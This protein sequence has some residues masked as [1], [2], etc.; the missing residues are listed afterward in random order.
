MDKRYILAE[1]G[2]RV[3]PEAAIVYKCSETLMFAPRGALI[4]VAQS[5]AKFAF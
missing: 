2:T 3:E 5:G 1:R 4:E